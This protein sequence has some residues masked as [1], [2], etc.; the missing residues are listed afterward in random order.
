M[1]LGENMSI[2]GILQETGEG[3]LAVLLETTVAECH[4]CL[5]ATRL[6]LRG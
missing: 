5:G 3:F 2:Q 4:S 6:G 1:D